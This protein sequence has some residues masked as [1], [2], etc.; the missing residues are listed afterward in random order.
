MNEPDG[1]PHRERLRDGREHRG[2]LCGG[3]SPVTSE[4]SLEGLP[5]EEIH[6]EHR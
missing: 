4:P 6:H 1:V 5:V 2:E 3:D